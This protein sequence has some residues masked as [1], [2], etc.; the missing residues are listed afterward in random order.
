LIALRFNVT[1]TLDMNATVY[2]MGSRGIINKFQK[3]FEL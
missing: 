1:E 3:I 2:F